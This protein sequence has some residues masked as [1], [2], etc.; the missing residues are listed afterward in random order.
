MGHRHEPHRFRRV[1]GND[2]LLEFPVHFRMVLKNEVSKRTCREQLR[3]MAET[4]KKWDTFVRAQ[5]PDE[6]E[7]QRQREAALPGKVSFLIPTYNTEPALL[8]A[9]V[10]SLLAQTAPSWEAC[11]YDGGSERQESIDA[12][13]AETERD[14]RLRVTFGKE[15][16]GISGNT[17][18]A[19]AMAEGDWCALVD[20][21]DLLSPEA[22]YRILEAAADGADMVYSDEDKCSED[23]S[24]FFDPRLKPDFS[25]DTLRSGNYICHLMAM[26]TEL[27]RGVGGLRSV[28]DGSQDHDL[29]LRAS[30][31]AEKVTHIRRVLY[32]WRM[33]QSSWSHS[34]ARACAEAAARAVGDQCRRLKLP[35]AAERF[36]LGVKLTA[37]EPL[38]D[39]TLIVSGTGLKARLRAARAARRAGKRPA[40]ILYAGGK[41]AAMP[42]A[43][44][45][46]VKR[47]QTDVIVF[48]DE[49]VRVRKDWLEPL[50]RFVARKDVA[51]AGGVLWQSYTRL[52]HAGYAVDIP[53][54]AVSCFRGISL[55][56]SPLLGA[57]MVNR[58]VTAVSRGLMMIRKDMFEKLGGFG[59]YI[60]DLASVALGLKAAEQGYLNVSVWDAGCPGGK[61]CVLEG[62]PPKS[63]VEHFRKTF[64]E[65]PEER[66][67]HPLMEETGTMQPNIG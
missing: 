24:R 2:T 60:S 42:V 39:W 58:N 25:P 34:K 12:L 5:E 53:A 27:M 49:S 18:G 29:A 11:F 50:W 14:P 64:G 48:L 65:H 35:V 26:K 28:C 10:D 55:N 57:D 51:C 4:E 59:L 38:P 62:E 45:A 67:M 63:D 61:N 47:V 46:A 21:D 56:A 8:R 3:R 9:L 22:V 40:A 19:L 44:N 54:G 36:L 37:T 6:L 13:K 31:R 66:Y 7:K 15:N 32:H 41:G 20:H 43:L 33:V 30:E 16:L 52:R 23:G 1:F 17:N